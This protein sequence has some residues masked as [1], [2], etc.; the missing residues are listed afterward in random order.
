MVKGFSNTPALDTTPRL[1]LGEMLVAR[2]L[3]TA[4]QLRQALEHQSQK[5]HK[6]LL[7]EVLIDLNFVTEQQV[8]EVLAEGYGVPFVTHTTRIADPKVL[9][10]L[11]RDFL[12]DH[13]VLPLFLVRGTLTVAVSEPTNLFLI[14]EIQRRTGYEVQIVAATAGEIVSSLR[15]YL[16]A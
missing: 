9:E 14:E 5:G 12:E 1:Q 11:P 2:G 4:D 6:S 7:G 10:I 15:S 3:I 16:P 13:K 8:L